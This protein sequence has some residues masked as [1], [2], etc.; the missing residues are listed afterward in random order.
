MIVFCDIN[1]DH[2]LTTSYA[3]IMVIQAATHYLSVWWF[4]TFFLF[5]HILGIVTP[6]HFHIFQRGRY[7]TNQLCIAVSYHGDS[8]FSISMDWFKGKFT[9]NHRFSH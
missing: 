2:S 9:G 1:Y 4:G 8:E 5:S 7:T 6:T 3:T